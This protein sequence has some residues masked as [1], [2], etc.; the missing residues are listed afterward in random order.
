M[1]HCVTPPAS[2]TAACGER[3]PTHAATAP[4]APVAGRPATCLAAV[5]VGPRVGHGQQAGA[6]VPHSKALVREG[7]AID[8]LAARAW[9]EGQRGGSKGRADWDERETS[10]RAGSP[11]CNHPSN[12]TTTVEA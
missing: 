1:S 9:E 3:S 6:V 12:Q 10:W 4:L 11:A 5:C 2:T 7:A 8:G